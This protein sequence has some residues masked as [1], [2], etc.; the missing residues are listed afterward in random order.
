MLLQ[1]CLGI[2]V[3]GDGR[4]IHVQRAELPFGI[5]DVTIHD[6]AVGDQRIDLAFRST[7]SRVAAFIEGDPDGRVSLQVRG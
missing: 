1:A 4:T 5:Q 2:Q 3:D 6:L 7:G